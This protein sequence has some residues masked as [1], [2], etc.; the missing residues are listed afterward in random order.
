MVLDQD[1]N[2]YLVSLSILITSLLDNV[3]LDII[4]RIACYSLL[5][6]KGLNPLNPRCE[7]LFSLSVHVQAE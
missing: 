6:V 2:L 5:G 7:F 3:T 1:N 4:G